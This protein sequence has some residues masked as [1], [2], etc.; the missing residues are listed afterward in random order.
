MIAPHAHQIPQRLAPLLLALLLSCGEDFGAGEV[1]RFEMEVEVPLI[2]RL[3]PE[4]TPASPIALALDI[5][6]PMEMSLLDTLRA[7]G[8]ADQA[9]MLEA[10]MD[11]IIS[12][13]LRQI[14]YEV[15]PNGVEADVDEIY[16]RMAPW[17]SADL[18]AEAWALGRTVAIPAG[19]TI[20]ERELS[21]VE[22]ALRKAGPEIRTL[23]FILVAQTR[24]RLPAE[25]PLYARRLLLR[26]RLKLLVRFDLVG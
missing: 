24:V 8:Q 23:R 6:A 7:Q 4:D 1:S 5:N 17:G 10:Q 25:T 9:Q 12:V 18:E 14:R 19:R 2:M 26:L 15:A 3:P 22:G 16:L 21:Y 11:R 20:A 13:D